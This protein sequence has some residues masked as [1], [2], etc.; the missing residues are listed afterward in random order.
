MSYIDEEIEKKKELIENALYDMQVKRVHLQEWHKSVKSLIER[1]KE[2]EEKKEVKEPSWKEY[3]E[4]FKKI[5]TQEKKRALQKKK[6]R[7]MNK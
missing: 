7:E 3:V 1:L 2:L 5:Q 4:K 6:M